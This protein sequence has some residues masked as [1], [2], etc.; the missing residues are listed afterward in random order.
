MDNINFDGFTLEFGL[1]IALCIVGL[2]ISVI[3]AISL[4]VSVWL[5]LKYWQ[6]AL[7]SQAQGN[8]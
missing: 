8:Q 7:H 6:G 2:L 4:V 1:Q 3:G 5:A